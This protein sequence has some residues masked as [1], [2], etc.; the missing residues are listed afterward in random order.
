MTRTIEIT[1]DGKHSKLSV[2][3]GTL[4]DAIKEFNKPE[5]ERKADAQKLAADLIYCALGIA[6]DTGKLPFV[7]LTEPAQE[8]AK[9]FPYGP[10]FT[11]EQNRALASLKAA[12]SPEE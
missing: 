7:K 6:Y 11:P 10:H 2:Q 9:L 3:C 4:T 12:L 5:D 1:V 8:I